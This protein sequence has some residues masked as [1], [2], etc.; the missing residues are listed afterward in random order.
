MTVAAAL[1]VVAFVLWVLE[2]AG[3]IGRRLSI[4]F[5]IAVLALPWLGTN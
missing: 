3:V 2:E 5:V 4:F 1:I